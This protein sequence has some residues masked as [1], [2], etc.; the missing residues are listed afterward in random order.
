MVNAIMVLSLSVTR[1]VLATMASVILRLVFAVSSTFPTPSTL[2]AMMAIFALM[3]I[4]VLMDLARERSTHHCPSLVAL[5]LVALLL[6][7]LLTLSRTR[8][9]SSLELLELLP[10]LESSLVSPFCSSESRPRS[11]S[12]PIHGILILSALLPAVL[13]IRVTPR[14]SSTHCTKEPCKS[15][16]GTVFVWTFIL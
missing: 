3:M 14:T 12:M 11:C 6:L 1:P 15:S 16:S 4:S 2:L 10:S 8:Q 7:L 5:L 9:P 13:S